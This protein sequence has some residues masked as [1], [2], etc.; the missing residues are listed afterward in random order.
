MLYNEV[1][2]LVLLLARKFQSK[3]V[4]YDFEGLWMVKNAKRINFSLLNGGREI[5]GEPAAFLHTLHQDPNLS[6]T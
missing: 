3:R 5:F 1:L 6:Y 4:K 2:L